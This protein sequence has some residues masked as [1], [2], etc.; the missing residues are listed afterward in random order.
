[1]QN[2]VVSL[3]KEL[4]K[5]QKEQAKGML[6]DL[7]KQIKE[8]NGT[9]FLAV[10]LDLDPKSIKDLVF[11]M[12]TKFE[13][14]FMLVANEK[15]GKATLSCYV[16]KSLVENKEMHAGTIV[17]E[18]AKHINGGGGGQAFFATAG[19][20]NPAGIQAALDGASGYLVK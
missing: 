10:Q 12:S 5:L 3:N 6:G 11:D 13:N 19:G 4:L 16:A 14:L 1:M 15:D 8:V 20:K 17:R 2:E 18:L 7:E 9:N